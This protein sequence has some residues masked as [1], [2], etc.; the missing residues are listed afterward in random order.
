MAV[1]RDFESRILS[2]Q[3][4]D[5]TKRLIT[6]TAQSESLARL[7]RSFRQFMRS[8]GGEDADRPPT[9][10]NP[11]SDFESWSTASSNAEWALERDC[12]LARL[13]RENEELR[14]MLG[15]EV[16]NSVEGRN[17]NE[18]PRHLASIPSHDNRTQST[19]PAMVDPVTPYDA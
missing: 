18:P 11:K 13:E 16:R 19:A 7:S 2:L 15:V 17:A 5:S 1:I 6:S 9:N 12:E 14:R 4:E 3:D 8:V 10:D